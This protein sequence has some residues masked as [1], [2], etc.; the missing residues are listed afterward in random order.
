ML[1]QSYAGEGLRHVHLHRRAPPGRAARPEG[2]RE[3]ELGASEAWQDSDLTA[4]RSDH[5]R[6]GETGTGRCALA[7]ASGEP[8]GAAGLSPSLYALGPSPRCW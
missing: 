6:P 5:G 3:G 7:R 4:A 2:G 8:M 1:A